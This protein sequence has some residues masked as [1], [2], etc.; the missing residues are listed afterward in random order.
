MRHTGGPVSPG[1][2]EEQM[3]TA[4]TS[5]GEANLQAMHWNHVPKM[6][7]KGPELAGPGEA[8]LHAMQ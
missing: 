7:R 4:L 8:N 6:P 2:G 5:P 1:K 3:E